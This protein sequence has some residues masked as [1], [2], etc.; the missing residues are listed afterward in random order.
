MSTQCTCLVLWLVGETYW[1]WLP[2]HMNVPTIYVN[3]MLILL[4]ERASIRAKAK[5]I[6][7]SLQLTT[8]IRQPLE[9]NV[10]NSS[11]QTTTDSHEV[12]LGLSNHSSSKII[13]SHSDA[14][15]LT[16]VTSEGNTVNDGDHLC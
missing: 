7:T 14:P 16:T 3:T 12:A 10:I 4:N 6:N 1:Y 9:F 5:V 15:S 2:V 8:R 11:R 13:H